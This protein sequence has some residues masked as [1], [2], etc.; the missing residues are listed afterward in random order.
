[1]G[2]MNVVIKA[3]EVRSDLKSPE[4]GSSSWVSTKNPGH[5]INVGDSVAFRVVEVKHEGAF[6][7]L[8][9]SLKEKD[10]GNVQAV[11]LVVKAAE[12]KAT[13]KK[14]KEDKSSK[15]WSSKRKKEE[16]KDGSSSSDDKDKGRIKAGNG[17]AATADDGKKKRRREKDRKYS[18]A[19]AAEG[20]SKA[21][22][23]AEDASRK[24]NK[25]KKKE[26]K[27]KRGGNGD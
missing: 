26:K 19:V 27:G 24:V 23:N 13:T 14:G 20:D 10:T 4:F 9:G 12:V 21:K 8:T 2:F 7:T 5:E 15:K 6:V 3:P 18:S 11:G 25:E 22:G 16:E 1:M 17:V